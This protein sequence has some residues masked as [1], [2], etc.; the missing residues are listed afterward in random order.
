MKPWGLVSCAVAGLVLGY[1]FL[2]PLFKRGEEAA[3]FT[4]TLADGMSEE[5]VEMLIAMHEFLNSGVVGIGV[6]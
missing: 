4:V 5:D 1:V 3:E 2:P 6:G